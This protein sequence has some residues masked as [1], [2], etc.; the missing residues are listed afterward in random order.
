M[1]QPASVAHIAAGAWLAALGVVAAGC[2]FGEGGMGLPRQVPG[3]VYPGE[4][5]EIIGTLQVG[6]KGCFRVSDGQGRS[7]FVIW[8]S[9]ASLGDL[10]RLG[11]FEELR[12]G[13]G[14]RGVGA[15]TPAKPLILD[16]GY[17][18]MALGFC[19]P[20]EAEVLVLDEVRRVAD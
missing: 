4:R 6:D 1:R 10:V 12:E 2:S 20:G 11:W 13:D 18:A 8:P 7:S 14:L 15:L 19:A 9:S 5:R 3:E 16:G 17:W